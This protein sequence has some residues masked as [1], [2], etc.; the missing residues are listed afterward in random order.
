MA[1][2]EL[3]RM[4]ID[5]LSPEPF[6]LP[7]RL[8]RAYQ[9]QIADKPESARLALLVAAA[10]D[11]GDLALVLRVLG[12]LGSTVEGLAIAEQSGMLTVAGQSITFHHPLKRAAAYRIAPFTQRL[13]V[14]AAIAAALTDQPDRR[15]WHLAAAAAGPD[16]TA[17]AALEAAAQRAHCRTGIATAATALERAARLSPD[18]ADRVRRLLLAVEAA[19]EAGQPE[20]ALR[21]A[22]EI[23]GSLTEW[24]SGR[25]RLV[26]VRARVELARGSLREAH[27]LLLR[28]ASYVAYVAPGQAAESLIHASVAAWI[29]G[30]LHGITEAQ[31]AIAELA[32]GPEHEKL[33]AVLEGP[34][35][36]H[37]D[38]PAEG[39]RRVRALLRS[40]YTSEPGGRSRWRCRRPTRARST[41]GVRS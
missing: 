20:R 31:A 11:S 7:D 25:A 40:G 27:T 13:A 41:T 30:N 39:V 29:S 33:L 16:E 6:P 14:H 28:S 10:E 12:E 34:I 37:S 19:A 22:D 24:P 35:G 36:L 8:Q 26:H 23:D 4:D 21:L 18:S 15:A 9:S 1:L 32:L 17:A 3:P 2:L 5:A 38:D